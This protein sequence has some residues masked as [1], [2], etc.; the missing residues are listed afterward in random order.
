MVNEV[1]GN[2]GPET[3]VLLRV[4]LRSMDLIQEEMER[5]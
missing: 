5:C 2:K 1:A 4:K 3:W